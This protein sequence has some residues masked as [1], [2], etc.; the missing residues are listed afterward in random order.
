MVQADAGSASRMVV[1]GGGFPPEAAGDPGSEGFGNGLLGS[2]TGSQ[3]W[4]GIADGE[5]VGDLFLGED[6]MEKGFTMAP[7]GGLDSGDLD[8]I[9]PDARNVGRERG[10][11]IQR[12]ILCFISRTASPMPVRRARLMMA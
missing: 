12:F 4:V 3:G 10:R 6:A 7:M 8:Q 5:A 1:N 11:Q 2:E 9:E